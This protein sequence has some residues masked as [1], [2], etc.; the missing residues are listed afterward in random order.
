MR[1]DEFYEQPVSFS[2]STKETSLAK[3]NTVPATDTAPPRDSSPASVHA[4]TQVI[5]NNKD[6]HSF[7]VDDPGFPR[8]KSVALEKYT[9]RDTVKV[10]VRF[11]ELEAASELAGSRYRTREF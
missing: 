10:S 9:I 3:V 11:A 7:I 5:L 1:R 2:E 8:I 6:E 4:M